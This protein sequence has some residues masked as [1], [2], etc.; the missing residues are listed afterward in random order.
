V[1]ILGPV[2]FPGSLLVGSDSST[3]TVTSPSFNGRT[4]VVGDLVH[5]GGSGSGQE[6]HTYPYRGLLPSCASPTTSPSGSG[7]PSGSASPSSSP[8]GSASS[9]SPS[10]SASPSS[11]P[12]STLS[13]DGPDDPALASTGL[14]LSELALLVG[15]GLLVFGAAAVGLTARR[16][17]LRK[18]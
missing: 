16:E 4:Y 1:G 14:P 15:M 3:T 6:L 17:D 12:T 13:P 18:R 9:S 10:G 11:S 7:S 2:V 8:S 5:G